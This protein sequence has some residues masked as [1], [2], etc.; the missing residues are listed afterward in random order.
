MNQINID[1][2]IPQYIKEEIEQYSL[3]CKNGYCRHMKWENIKCL[4]GLA[5]VNN[6]ITKEQGEFLI[7][8]FYIC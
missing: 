3:D 4:I 8:N 7:K 5:V 1:F 6:R 2:E